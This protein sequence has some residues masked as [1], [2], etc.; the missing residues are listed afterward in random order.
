MA[1]TLA[2]PVPDYEPAEVGA[3]RITRT[4]LLGVPTS[5]REH[6]HAML[7]GAPGPAVLK[8]W[9]VMGTYMRGRQ[10]VTLAV[11][12]NPGSSLL[13]YGMVD[14]RPAVLACT[15]CQDVRPDAEVTGQGASLGAS[16]VFWDC[17][18]TYADPA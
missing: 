12:V 4:D 10:E 15:R 1:I 11:R 7:E 2:R 8:R 6:A 13:S 5:L 18:G 14:Y 3:D 9:F 16:C 17:N